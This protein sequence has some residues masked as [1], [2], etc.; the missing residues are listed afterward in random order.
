MAQLRRTTIALSVFAALCLSACGGGGGKTPRPDTGPPPANPGNPGNPTPPGPA[1]LAAPAN[2]VAAAGVASVAL[3]W[4]AVPGALTYNVY[5][6]TTPGGQGATPVLSNLTATSTTVQGLAPGATYYFIVRAAN[7]DGAGAASNEA[8]AVPQ[9]QAPTAALE[10]ASLELA[11]AHVLPAQGLSWTLPNASESYHAVGGRA[12]L[13]LLRLSA[14]NAGNVRLEGFAN[15][16][17]LGALALAP[18]SALPPTEDNGQAY[19]SDLYSAEI[20]AAWMTSALQLRVV[21]DNYRAGALQAPVIGA[22]SDALV[23]ILPFYLFGATPDNSYPLSEAGVAPQDAVDQIY[24]QWPVARLV[25][26]S[27]PAQAVIW[28][29][30]AVPPVD[31]NPAFLARAK[32]DKLDGFVAMGVMLN[33]ISNL[34][35]ANGDDLGQ[36]QGYVPLIMFDANGKLAD[37]GGGLGGFSVGSGGVGYS[38]IFIHEQGHAMGSPHQGSAYKD[39]KYPYVGGSLAGSAWG[40]DQ[41]NRRFQ[42][43]FVP[44]SAS[45]YKDCRADTFDGSPRQLDAQGRCVRQDPMQS[46]SGDQAKGYR[47]TI[48]SDYTAAMFQRY[49]EGRTTVAADGTHEHDGSAVVADAAYPGGY[50]IWDTI[51]R[52]WVNYA[53]TTPSYGLYEFDG[54]LPQQRN[55]PVHAISLSY[56]YAGTPEVSQFYPPLSFVG[57]LIRYID[58]T[59]A[60]QRASIDPKTGPY[61]WYCQRFGCDYTLRVTY[62]DGSLRHVVLR[63]GFRTWFGAESPVP[64]SAKDPLNGDSF[65]RW[66]VQVPG[67]KP[68]RKVE[69]L[70]TPMVWQGFPAN[71]TVLVSRDIASSA[72]PGCVELPTRAAP[73]SALPAPRCGQAAQARA[74][75][76][77]TRTMLLQYLRAARRR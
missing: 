8:Q 51:D 44:S 71:P 34:L 10:I 42:G 41:V 59:D 26:Q 50:R 11:Q 40:Y 18:P 31:G 25:I 19:A 14:N 24:A 75:V 32:D 73:A 56:S 35:D 47:F 66:L 20:P 22:D 13:A 64:D 65:Q 21:A 36:V 27:H 38:G 63:S 3:T 52:R 54:K 77:A 15:G 49:Y 1:A 76:E 70:D 23:R 68:L 55:V 58:P 16:A 12:A 37:S 30:L 29:T 7:A 74:A 6:A 43:P 9:A 33:L 53:P 67:D 5:Q 39:G 60:A 72:V 2:L 48:F 69:M 62:T 61:R 46:G 4:D 17:P 57:N 28:P 45:R